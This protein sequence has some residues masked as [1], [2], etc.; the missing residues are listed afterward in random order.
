LAGGGKNKIKIMA[1]NENIDERLLA[2]NT[3]GTEEE[4]DAAREL[5]ER[6]KGGENE[7]EESAGG[8][9]KSLREKVMEARQALDIKEKLEKT[10]AAPIKS[11]SGWILRWAWGLTASWVG[12]IPGLLIINLYV[13]LRLVFGEKLFCKLGEE[14]IPKQVSQA[15][16]GIGNM[17]SKKIG[18]VEVAGLVLLDLLLVVIIIFIIG[19]ILLIFD[20]IQNP[21]SYIGE[22]LGIIWDKV[23]G[24]FAGK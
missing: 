13:F 7:E 14:W 18:I 2:G 21:F 16:G 9:A 19:I 10:V 6:K 20:V 22:A 23:T 24:V 12:F 8:E 11:G 5:R 4:N 15:A 17:A 1:R 3:L